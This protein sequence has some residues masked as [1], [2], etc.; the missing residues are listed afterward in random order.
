MSSTNPAAS[1]DPPPEGADAG[2]PRPPVVHWWARL[3]SRIVFGFLS[4]LILIA[5]VAGFGIWTEGREHLTE[6]RFRQHEAAGNTVVAELE[7]RLAW[8]E[9]LVTSI[10]VVA[11]EGS[12]DFDREQIARVI[13]RMLDPEGSQGFVA[14]GGVWPEANA[15]VPGVE[16]ASLFWGRDRTGRLIFYDDYNAPDGPGYHREEWY[17]PARHLEADRVYWSRTY[18]DPYTFQ[19]M[20]T[21]TAPMLRDGRFIGV[22][23]IDLKLEGLREIVST[24][25]QR[26]GGYGY[27]LDRNDTFVTHP[28]ERLVVR[29]YTD[30]GGHPHRDFLSAA[31][32]SRGRPEFAPIANAVRAI[33]DRLTAETRSQDQTVAPLARQLVSAADSIDPEEAL[34]V[35][36]ILRSDI[37]G[38]DGGSHFRRRLSLSTDV[39]LGEPVAAS[40]FFMQ[41]MHWKVVTIVPVSHVT[42]ETTGI[43]RDYTLLASLLV[44]LAVVLVWATLRRGVM[45]PLRR[46]TVDLRRISAEGDPGVELEPLGANNELDVLAFWFNHRTRLLDKARTSAEHANRS[47]SEFLANMSHEIRTPM[48]A[49]LGYT[50]VL[51]DADE[52][53]EVKQSATEVIKKNGDHLLSVIND[54]LDLSKLESGKLEVESRPTPIRD[55]VREVVSLLQMRAVEKRIA[56]TLEIDDTVPAIVRTDP[57]RVRQVLLN[58]VGNAVKFTERGG[59]KVVARWAASTSGEKRLAFEVIDTGIGMSPEALTRLFDPFSQAD[60]TMTRRFG[61]SGLGLTIS[62]RLARLLGGDIRVQ[63]RLDVGSRFAF[64]FDPGRTEAGD[65][66][67]LEATRRSG[68]AAVS[69]A[70]A[71]TAVPTDLAGR[72]LL[73]EDVKV[74][75]ELLRRIL[76]KAGLTVE[77]VEH[78]QEALDR[79]AAVHHRG[80]CFDVIIMD[81]QMPVMDGHTAIGKLREDGYPGHVIACTAHALGGDREKCLESGFD[82]CVTKPI[83]RKLLLSKLSAVLEAGSSRPVDAPRG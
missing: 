14:G 17:V 69:A 10:A 82:D 77:A 61:G 20:V 1:T 55:L 15:F 34:R 75:R 67:T 11:A 25:T 79:V 46:M 62:L 16:R 53:D 21:C 83:D 27:I 9:A 39:L 64:T 47:K 41:R 28:V 48:T 66:A 40:I 56:L 12:R 81:I 19:P 72:I 33:E 58:L 73:V 2:V 52:P 3:E 24:I 37:T 78:G 57:L 50:D 35:A 51:L 26:L 22:A 31:D 68:G 42:A 54:L 13:P 63:S 4:L 80:E 76:E 38:F 7:Q 23:T 18:M 71:E 36:A 32:L 45:S 49:I 70:G 8:A 43:L 74:N 65:E 30:A 29:S 44:G 60:S 5:G 6:G 59:V